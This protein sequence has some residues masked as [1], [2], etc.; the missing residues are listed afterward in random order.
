MPIYSIKNRNVCFH[1][2]TRSRDGEGRGGRERERVQIYITLRFINA[3]AFG[4]HLAT[5]DGFNMPF[6]YVS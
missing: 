5:A 3:E 4:V 6:W 1:I 2:F